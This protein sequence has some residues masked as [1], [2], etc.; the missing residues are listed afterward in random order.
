VMLPPGRLRLETRPRL[1][2]SPP[3]VN[4]IGIVV[5]AA[6]AAR[7][8]ATPT[9]TITAT[10]RRTRSAASGARRSDR[11]SAQP[12]TSATFSPSR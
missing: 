4:T 3:V 8:E 12:Y 5:V 6:F 9:G 7:A 2:G 1:T 11:F 10:W